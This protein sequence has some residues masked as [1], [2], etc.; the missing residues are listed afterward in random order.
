MKP[1]HSDQVNATLEGFQVCRVRRNSHVIIQQVI[2]DNLEVT[3]HSR[4]E[5]E[6]PRYYN[7]KPTQHNGLA[8]VRHSY[9]PLT[10]MYPVSRFCAGVSGRCKDCV[11]SDTSTCCRWFGFCLI[12]CCDAVYT[13]LMIMQFAPNS[14]SALFLHRCSCERE[15]GCRASL[16][17]LMDAGSITTG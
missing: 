4:G 15:G 1:G 9:R 11:K 8:Y 13:S 3:M 12:T 6:S 10:L 17:I 14:P 16:I 2:N 7:S 5:R